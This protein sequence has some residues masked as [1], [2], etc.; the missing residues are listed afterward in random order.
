MKE[1]KVNQ[2][3]Y[4]KLNP[5]HNDDLSQFTVEMNE[6]I[7]ST[8][9]KYFTSKDLGWVYPGKSYMVAICYARWIHEHWGDDFYQLLDD[10]ML[11]Y[12]NDPYF[13]PYSKA[14]H[15]YDQI[16]KTIGGLYFDETVGFVPDVKQYFI[17]EFLIDGS[18]FT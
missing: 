4:H 16:L 8:A 11:L 5:Q 14:S 13:T 15:V 17:E 10:P 12:G 2:E 7:V 9:V 3:L 6:D 18:D 1:W